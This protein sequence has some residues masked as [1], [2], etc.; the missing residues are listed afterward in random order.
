MLTVNREILSFRTLAVLPI[1]L[2]V[3]TLA[4]GLATDGSP[5]GE[6]VGVLFHLSILFVVSRMN[7]P[8]WAKAAGFGWLALDI[9]TGAMLINNVPYDIAWPVRLGGHVLAGVWTITVSLLCRST[10]IRAVG[11]VSGLW[12][13]L[14]TFFGA[15]LSNLWLSPQ[16]FLTLV[17][18]GLLAWKYD[19]AV[20]GLD[21]SQ[22]YGDASQAGG[23]AT[24]V[25]AKSATT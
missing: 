19:P 1:V 8:I 12:L 7:A 22:A 15:V 11:V 25:P 3:P 5:V 21:A 16:A 2:F 4:L 9:T 24:P 20:D 14:Y 17:W 18:F 10:A 23:T 6:S 13:A